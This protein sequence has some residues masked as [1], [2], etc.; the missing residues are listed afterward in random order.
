MHEAAPRQLKVFENLGW[1][2][3]RGALL[4]FCHLTIYSSFLAFVEQPLNPFG[5]KAINLDE[6][7]RLFLNLETNEEANQGD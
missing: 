1:V 2:A 7:T 3:L 5:M 6:T 4:G